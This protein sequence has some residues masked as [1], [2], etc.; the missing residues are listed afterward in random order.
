MAVRSRLKVLIAERNLERIKQGEPEL[1]IRQIAAGT[2]LPSS[3]VS[4]LTSGR[5]VRVDFKT[6]NK[7]CVY[8]SVQP[9]DLLEYVPDNETHLE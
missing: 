5:A 1:T 3:V 2:G 9:G 4:G 6:L 8:F 7:L